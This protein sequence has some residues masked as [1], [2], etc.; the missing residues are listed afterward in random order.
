[1]CVRERACVYAI[2]VAVVAFLDQC[3]ET[4]LALTV[5]KDFAVTFLWPRMIT[6]WVT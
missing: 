6:S 1:M 5:L 4:L 2:Q 3:L